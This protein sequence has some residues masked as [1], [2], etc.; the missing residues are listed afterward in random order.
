MDDSSES[1]AGVLVLFR[2]VSADVEQLTADHLGLFV[3][4]GK[5]W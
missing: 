2:P 1:D 3:G 4:V 5:A